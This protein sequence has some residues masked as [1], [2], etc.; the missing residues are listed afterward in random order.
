MAPIQLAK[1]DAAGAQ[2]MLTSAVTLSRTQGD[3]VSLVAALRAMCDSYSTH[4]P[5]EETPE[6]VLLARKQRDYLA[7][8]QPELDARVRA[9]VDSAEHAA[10]LRWALGE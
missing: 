9:A 1:G 2:Q 7:R 5:R 8:K 6:G 3:L 4:P 10:L